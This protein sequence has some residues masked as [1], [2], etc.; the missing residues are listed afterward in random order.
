MVTGYVFDENQRLLS[1]AMIKSIDTL[2]LTKT[3]S[4]GKFYLE[5]HPGK[6]VLRATW[7]GYKLNSTKVINLSPGDCV[8]INFSMKWDNTPTI[9]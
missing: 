3:N 8:V 6:N 4:N 7:I 5:V 9:N 2:T 1:S